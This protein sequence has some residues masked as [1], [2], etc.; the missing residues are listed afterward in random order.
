MLV[1]RPVI[2]C[3]LALKSCQAVYLKAVLI[4][5]PLA[6]PRS[7]FGIRI[8][9]AEEPR[10]HWGPQA[11]LR[12]LWPGTILSARPSKPPHSQGLCFQQIC[13]PA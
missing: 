8:R 1:I 9:G 2:L 10:T 7:P 6:S 3:D 11:D 13:K 12:W 5:G 4:E